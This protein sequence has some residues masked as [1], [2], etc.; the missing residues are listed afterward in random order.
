MISLLVSWACYSTRGR[1]LTSTPAQPNST[2]PN[3]KTLHL[4][5]SPLCISL[6][7]KLNK[8]TMFADG[9]LHLYKYRYISVPPMAKKRSP[10][11]VNL[12]ERSK[13]CSQG[14]FRNQRRQP[15]DENSRVIGIGGSELL[16]IWSNEVAKDSTCLGV[17]F[18][19]LFGNDV[20]RCHGM[21]LRVMG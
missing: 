21:I 19:R 17:M 9:H 20:P 2:P 14:F 3:R 13:E 18:P 7:N 8:A 16:A 5:D 1:T 15:T 12:A 11:V 6:S 10:H 4:L